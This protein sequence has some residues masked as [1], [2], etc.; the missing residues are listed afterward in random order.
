MV[1]GA[2]IV[3]AIAVGLGLALSTPYLRE[4]RA[5]LPGARWLGPLHGILGACG[6]TLLLAAL[7]GPPRGVTTGTAS[8]G[9]AAAL[10]F[11]LALVL[12]IAIWLLVRRNQRAPGL[13]VAVHAGV[14]ITGMT[15][16]LAWAGLE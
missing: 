14:A 1:T 4:D 10:V 12:G 2:L 8:F 3:L 16:F 9:P 7:T 13:L 11:G 15:M 6:L 5:R